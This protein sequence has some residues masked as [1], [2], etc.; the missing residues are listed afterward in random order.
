MM[1]LFKILIVWWS[2]FFVPTG[3]AFFIDMAAPGQAALGF[4]LFIV[5][6]VISVGINEN[7]L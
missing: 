2:I 6:G 5:A 4:G 1:K 3:I 7:K